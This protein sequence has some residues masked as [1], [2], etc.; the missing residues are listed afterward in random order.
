[1]KTGIVAGA[2]DVIHAGYIKMFLDAKSQCDHLIVALHEDPSLERP[3]KLQPSQSLEDRKIILSSIKYIDEIISYKTE[4]D[5]EQLLVEIKP[6]IRILGSDYKDK[7]FT[8]KGLE[9]DLYFH[10]RDHSRSTTS[11]K[12]DIASRLGFNT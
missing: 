2:F 1:M 7:E 10:D 3:K 11:L 6:D 12:K 8:G 4:L 5:F 9:I